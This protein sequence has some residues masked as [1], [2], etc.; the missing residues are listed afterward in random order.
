MTKT[1]TMWLLLCSAWLHG[2]SHWECILLVSTPQTRVSPTWWPFECFLAHL[3]QIS[4]IFVG[5]LVMQTHCWKAL[6]E[7]L[8]W[9]LASSVAALPGSHPCLHWCLYPKPWQSEKWV[10]VEYQLQCGVIADPDRMVCSTSP[11]VR[12]AASWSAGLCCTHCYCYTTNT[13]I[14]LAIAMPMLWLKA[15]LMPVLQITCGSFSSWNIY[16]P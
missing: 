11:Y 16:T 8:N 1:R 4:F 3:L 5:E 12:Q 6:H 7:S 10:K 13:P 9:L 15:F 14:W 2:R